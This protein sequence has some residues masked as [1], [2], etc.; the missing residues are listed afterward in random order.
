[1]KKSTKFIIAILAIAAVCFALIETY[2]VDPQ[3][4][5]IQK[6]IQK[7]RQQGC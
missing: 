3:E 6:E 5:A 2:E 4:A 7:R 1:M